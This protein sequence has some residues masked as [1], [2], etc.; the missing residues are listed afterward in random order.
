[1]KRFAKLTKVLQIVSMVCAVALLLWLLDRIGWAT[2]ASAIRRVGFVGAAVLCALA[3]TET[4]LDSAALRI[5]VGTRLGLRFFAPVNGAGALL[6]LVLPWESG[7]VL[8]TALLRTQFGSQQAVSGT[9][10]WNYMYKLS[11]PTVS[12]LAA[13]LAFLLSRQTSGATI[14]IV[15]AANALAFL[16]YLVLRVVV[17]YGAAQGVMRI[18]RLIP[19][20][21]RHP[22]HWL[23][24]ARNI[25]REVR[26]FWQMR[27]ADYLKAFV[28]QVF[29]RSTAWFSV[30]AGFRLVG[31]PYGFAE[32][33]LVY[34]T[35]NVAEYVIAILPARVGVAE[36]TAFFA[37]Q[38]LGLEPA[39]GLILYVVLRV[40]TVFTNGML[41]PWAFIG[42]K[43]GAQ[44]AAGDS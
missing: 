28:F 32:A 30:Y 43:K 26:Q 23:E 37:F 34:A 10:V 20:V 13:L 8:K 16:P 5:V 7:E 31:L 2:I 38:L 19:G 36:G 14:A 40:R 12:A 44:T 42:W 18:L 3:L 33:T 15:C 1:V 21:R 35:M 9:I 4:V 25:D 29:A 27:R 41:A 11:R 39:L 22:G 17:R 24:L 6:N